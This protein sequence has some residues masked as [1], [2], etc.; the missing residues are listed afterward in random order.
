MPDDQLAKMEQDR[1]DREVICLMDDD[2]LAKYVPIFG[3]RIAV[4]NFCKSRESEY[5]EKAETKK[6]NL[7]QKLRDKMMLHNNGKEVVNTG[8]DGEGYENNSKRRCYLK[9][10]RHAVKESRRIELGWLH[11]GKQVRKRNGGGTRVLEVSKTADKQALIQ[12]AKDL[13]F[14][15][16]NS[17]KGYLED[18]K[19]DILD[20]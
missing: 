16:G 4:R 2:S 18:F 19:Y 20:F 17:K 8:R 13:F 12:L 3:D 14:P 10:N 15:N 9:G 5:K 6:Q 11:E 1:I 7:L